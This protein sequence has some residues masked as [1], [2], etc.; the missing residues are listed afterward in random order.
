[1]DIIQKSKLD[2]TDMIVDEYKTNEK[3]MSSDC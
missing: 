3:L 1:M 2:N